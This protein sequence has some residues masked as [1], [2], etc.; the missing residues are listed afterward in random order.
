MLVKELAEIGKS[1]GD[2]LRSF[3]RHLGGDGTAAHFGVY[4]RGL[5]SDE[6]RKTPEPLALRAGTAVRTLQ[7]FL[8]SAVWDEEA[9]L[10]QVRHKLRLA[11]AAQPR[12]S[13]GTVGLIDET[14]VAKKGAKTPGVQ[15]QYLGCVGKVDNGIVT[16]H[17]GATRGRLKALLDADLFL[18]ASWDADRPRCA[19]AGIPD[20]K[21]HEPKW[22]LAF[23]Q[24]ARARKEGFRFDWLTF[25][26]G[27][28]CTPAFLKALDLTA[29]RYAAEV[30]VNYRVAAVAG[31][32]R[33]EVRERL[34]PAAPGEWRTLVRRLDSGGSS[35]WKYRSAAAFGA[36]HRQLMVLAVNADTGEVKY[37]ASNAAGSAPATVLR[38]GFRRAPVE[39]LFRLAKREAGLAHFEGRSYRGLVRH[40]ILALAVMAFA[41]MRAARPRKKS[42][43]AGAD[44]TVEQICRAVN[45][46]VGGWMR[47]LR[48]TSD[49][50]AAGSQIAYQQ[51]RNEAAR[52]SR[53]GHRERKIELSLAL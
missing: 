11:F 38:A 22:K 13:L 50:A 53:I 48:S 8:A 27:Y 12:G 33:V 46:V 5:L 40:M 2:Y 19:A 45:A 41:S 49:K 25:D 30:P 6:A 43:P 21:R 31:G 10:R 37:F 29:Q 1:Y 3:R 4:C 15:R 14:S 16:V 24:V 36:D 51:A 47:R 52:R 28:G 17:L 35:V 42:G 26:E 44:P 9:V 32:A 7:W 39:H 18:P 20:S 34:D 23:W